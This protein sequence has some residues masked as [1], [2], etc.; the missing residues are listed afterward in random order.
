MTVFEGAVDAIFAAFGIDALYTPAGGDPIPVRVSARHPDT[1]V[2]FGEIRRHR[3]LLI[4]ALRSLQDAAHPSESDP[5]PTFPNPT[6]LL[7][8]GFRRT[9]A[10]CPRATDPMLL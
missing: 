5:K 8:S 1:I 6:V 2:G 10:P 4:A 9:I 3:C 7:R